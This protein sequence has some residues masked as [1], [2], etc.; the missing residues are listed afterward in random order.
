MAP[1]TSSEQPRA[2][3]RY[4]LEEPIATGT[5][6]TIWRARDTR[7]RRT[8][9]IKRFH[10]HVVADEKGRRRIEQETAAARRVK[11]R[12]VVSAL[13]TISTPDELA[14]V[15]PYVEG[16]TLAARLKSE[17]RLPPRRA[18]AIAADVADALA[19]AHA[20][21]VVHRDV[22]PGNILVGSDGRARL[23]D[24]G[25][26]SAVGEAAAERGLTGA[27]LAIGTLPYMAPEQLAAEQPTTATDVF[28]LGVVLY[29]TL[30]G[31]RPFEAGSPVALAEAHRVPPARIYDAPPALV[32]LAFQA[33][34]A[35]PGARPSASAFG[36]ALRSWLTSSLQPAVAES[37]TAPV[38][39]AV[40]VTTAPRIGA[41]KRRVL[42]G[43]VAL[44]GLLIIAV[45]AVGALAPAAAP[46]P[47][48]TPTGV[49]V[50]IAPVTASPAAEPSP[51]ESRAAVP[52]PQSQSGPTKTPTSTP[53]NNPAPSAKPKPG[54]GHHH[55][56]HHKKGHDKKKHHGHG[57]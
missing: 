12:N 36:T 9:A 15:F 33:L 19:A 7:R 57:H 38:A 28:A 11:H 18:A 35:A 47:S 5:T 1:M 52:G 39:A 16:E 26:A 8:V 31:R 44:A 4:R 48:A 22:K 53:N 49:G 34:A 56:K 3:G 21:G 2:L 40:P 54:G 51:K 14:L 45:V 50:A 23:L 37:P 6:A 30:C 29:E 13:D 55:K 10:P 42:T 24:F 17:G 20:A 43:I 27:G 46:L 41:K 25:I 32:D